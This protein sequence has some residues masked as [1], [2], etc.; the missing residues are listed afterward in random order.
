MDTTIR[1]QFESLLL[2][3]VL[4]P[5]ETAFGD[6]GEIAIGEFAKILAEHHVSS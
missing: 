3:P 5:L 6:Y 2:E 1:A 4:K